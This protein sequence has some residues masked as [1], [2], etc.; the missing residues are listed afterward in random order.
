METRTLFSPPVVLFL[1]LEEGERKAYKFD[2]IILLHPH[3][4]GNF[5]L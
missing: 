4:S 2:R 1:H 3:P 5:L